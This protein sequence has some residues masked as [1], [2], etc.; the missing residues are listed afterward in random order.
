MAISTTWV[1]FV[2]GATG[3]AI[4]AA[5]NTFN[6]NILSDVVSNEGRLAIAEPK[7]TTNISDIA[8]IDVR[9]TA[10]E[11][12][13][14]SLEN[15]TKIPFIPQVSAPAHIEGQ[16]Y[17]DATQG[18]FKGQGPIPGVEISI[19]HGNHL[20]VVNNSGAVIE[21]GMAVRHD[22]VDVLGR[23][24]VVKAIAT[25]FTNALVFGVAQ[26]E[27]AAAVGTIGAI[28]TEGEIIGINT[29]ATT[30]GVPL[31][32]SDTVAG[33]WVETAPTIVT[34]IGGVTISDLTDGV[35]VVSLISNTSF[36]TIYGGL[37]GQVTPL[38]A[39]TAAAQDITN[40]VTTVESVVTVN[41]VT[42]EILLPNAGGYRANFAASMSFA[43]TSTT[44]VVFIEVY[45]VTGVAIAFSFVKNI[46]RDATQDSLSF[47]FPA[48][49]VV[50]N[51]IKMRIRSV[52][53]MDVTF[54]SIVFDI[55][56][57]TII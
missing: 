41:A 57:V 30:A 43:S 34:Q 7:I 31:Y 14:V 39:L 21:K 3:A 46:P 51:E 27:M 1:N 22:G 40:Y 33:T 52:P 23:V 10:A 35:L 2:N 29:S 20:H 47:S 19:G 42:G 4:R 55:E 56:S 38:Y 53:D 28:V 45:D 24:Q 50:D 54:D 16:V 6:T 11:G 26:E 9:V 15:P 12:D 32:L 48:Q 36:P 37:Q 13:I 49:A 8:D 17:Y 25:S 44:R 18:V 5:L